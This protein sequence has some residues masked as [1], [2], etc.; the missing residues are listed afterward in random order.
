MNRFYIFILLLFC[1]FNIKAQW[2]PFPM[3]QKG[4]Y[5]YEYISGLNDTT[6][7]IYYVDSIVDFGNYQIYHFDYSTPGYNGCYEAVNNDPNIYSTQFYDRVRP[8]SIIQ[9]NDSLWLVFSNGFP[10][11]F[12]DSILFL[13]KTE[14]DSSWFS[15][16]KFSPTVYDTLK[17]TCDSIYADTIT[18]NIV[19]SVKLFSIRAFKNSVPVVSGFDTLKLILSKNYGFK[20]FV[21]FQYVKN[22]PLI[23][24]DS[25]ITKAGFLLPQ[26]SDYFHLSAGDIVVW[27][28]YDY[29]D[30][31][32]IPN[33]TTYY[34]DSIVSVSSYPDSVIYDINRTYD[35][36]TQTTP[37]LKYVKDKLKGLTLSTSIFLD[38]N[39][40]DLPVYG[41]S[42]HDLY[43]SSEI[44]FSNDSI[45]NREYN[46]EGNFYDST[47]CNV[48][49]VA[50]AGFNVHYN[51]Y[52]GLTSY[53]SFSCCGYTTWSIVGSIISGVQIGNVWNVGIDK[54]KKDPVVEIYPNPSNHGNVTIKGEN[55][56]SFEILN[57]QGQLISTGKIETNTTQLTINNLAK[58]IYLV[59]I[60]F[61][62]NNSIIKKLVIN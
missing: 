27:K 57:L 28:Q 50:D 10:F 29:T 8:D 21:S 6:I 30:D 1:G 3:G 61:N 44:Y 12:T 20:Q 53:G 62:N 26:F 58:G 39:S 11:S 5:Q 41:F 54:I 42:P 22:I 18:G 40:V 60:V 43:F 13:P 7:N 48:Y 52:Y 47:N 45:I 59:K 25:G 33:T 15:P 14:K 46:F 35:F 56:E 4:F 55:M 24:I 16:A 34:K 19:D 32:M 51:T 38:A 9:Q 17:F 36:G 49:V 37:S 31:I 23:G 2:S